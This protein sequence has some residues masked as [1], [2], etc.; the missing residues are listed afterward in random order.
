MKFCKTCSVRCRSLESGRCV[1]CV[2]RTSARPKRHVARAKPVRTLREAVSRAPKGRHR[3]A[4]YVATTGGQ[5]RRKWTDPQ[6]TALMADMAGAA[7]FGRQRAKYLS[8]GE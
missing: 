1:S 8:K 6:L 5:E 3:L 2:T 4:E 7:R